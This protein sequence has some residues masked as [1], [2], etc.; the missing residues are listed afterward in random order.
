LYDL[1]PGSIGPGTTVKEIT[2]LRAEGGSLPA[3]SKEAFA[4]LHAN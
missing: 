1:P 2:D 4:E 3:M